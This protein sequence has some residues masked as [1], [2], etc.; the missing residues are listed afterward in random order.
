MSLAGE[1]VSPAATGGVDERI[2][3]QLK[4]IWKALPR[5]NYYQLLDLQQGASPDEIKAAFYRLSRD[6]HPDRYFRFP[7]ENFRNAV[8][9]IYR[10][11]SEGYTVLKSPMW[12]DAYDAQLSKDPNAVRFSIQDDEKRRQQGGSSYDG[13]TGPGKKYWQAAMEALRNKNLAG[14]KLQLQLAMGIEPGNA[15]FKAKLDELRAPPKP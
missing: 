1:G 5:L 7:N 9:T 2:V 10:R 12:R 8:S 15:E 3:N 4:L 6:Y 11:I 14:A 13:G